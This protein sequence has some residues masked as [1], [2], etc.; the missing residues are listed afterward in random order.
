MVVSS[1]TTLPRRGRYLTVLVTVGTYTITLPPTPEVGDIVTLLAFG[2]SGVV[3]I[4]GAGSDTI[5]GFTNTETLGSA[6]AYAARSFVCTTVDGGWSAYSEKPATQ[7]VSTTQTLTRAG[8][9]QFILADTSSESLTLTL[10]TRSQLGDCI[11]FVKM[12]AANSLTIQRNGSDQID[13]FRSVVTLTESQMSL[14][15]VRTSS[16]AA[17]AWTTVGEAISMLEATDTL[18]LSANTS[19]ETH[20][21]VRTSA[22]SWIAGSKQ[23]SLPSLARVGAK[24]II[25]DVDGSASS[26]PITIPG[27]N[28]LGTTNGA[29]FT[30]ADDFGAA[31]LIAKSSTQWVIAST[32]HGLV[33]LF[34]HMARVDGRVDSKVARLQPSPMFNWSARRVALHAEFN[35]LITNAL[36]VEGFIGGGS[37]DLTQVSSFF[38]QV[39]VMRCTVTQNTVGYIHLGN[40]PTIGMFS[41][42]QLLGF[43]AIF[44][45]VT[46]NPG[47]DYTIEI[48]FGDSISSASL[49]NN[50][51]FLHVAAGGSVVGSRRS[52]G[53]AVATTGSAG[54][55]TVPNKYVLEYYLNG[56]TWDPIV[57]GA[58]VPGGSS[59]VPGGILNFGMRI[60]GT[61][62]TDYQV[63]VDSFTIFTAD[64]GET[65]HN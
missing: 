22:A 5:H 45:P 60:T 15:L 57:N 3:T 4:D 46:A 59:S 19:S 30:I 13:G 49:G 33:D 28:V 53:G 54:T 37:M 24:L 65:R 48:G 21:M 16:A 39:G 55:L 50:S 43:R 10:P 41:A 34:T 42:L 32:T 29:S 25:S 31:T 23:I 6:S 27:V 36:P 18:S 11:T 2:G 17:S 40:A 44:K 47:V 38:G 7:S 56:A 9:T 58:R 1:A 35:G 63:D 12:A 8:A 51:L 62:A 14:T 20:V 52:G 64:M 26:N 61:G